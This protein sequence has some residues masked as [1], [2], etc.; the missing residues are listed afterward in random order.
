[1][2]TSFVRL[3][4]VAALGV[5][6]LAACGSSSKSSAAIPP[7]TTAAPGA[8]AY[9]GTTTTTGTGSGSPS[10]AAS[11]TLAMNP[12]IGKNILVDA[13]GMTLY[14][15]DADTTP[16]KS[17]CNAGCDTKWPALTV[18]GTPSYGDKL[19]AS[20]F[21]TFKR[22]DGS[23]QLAVNGHPLYHFANDAK[24]GDTKGNGIG[25]V[26]YV[27]GADGKKIDNS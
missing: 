16:G 24:A 1:M 27:V 18:T 7:T 22:D 21:S 6:A 15:F 26:W 25:N 5:L 2:R 12:K 10:G 23:T 19:D 3:L 20:M 4:A 11:V 13:K 17:V 8:T 14:T 9:G